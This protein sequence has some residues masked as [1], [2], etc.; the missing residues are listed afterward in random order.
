MRHYLALIGLLF[1]TNTV[2]AST[3]ANIQSLVGKKL[4]LMAF[5]INVDGL[6]THMQGR[7]SGP[8]LQNSMLSSQNDFNYSG[9]VYLFDE[10]NMECNNRGFNA[11]EIEP[12]RAD[13]AK[14]VFNAL[15]LNG[16][17]AGPFSS[18]RTDLRLIDKSSAPINLACSEVTT[19][20]YSTIKRISCSAKNVG[21]I[22]DIE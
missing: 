1:L 3:P 9:P 21:V 11:F 6:F 16:Y 12:N 20:W 13:P 15:N 4:K 7:C 5:T 10:T 19:A 22:F 17:V 14:M 8:S 2:H 18:E